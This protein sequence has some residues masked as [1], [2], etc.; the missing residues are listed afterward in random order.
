MAVDARIQRRL[1]LRND[2]R[3]RKRFQTAPEFCELLR[4]EL[5]AS[6]AIRSSRHPPT[7]YQ[8]RYLFSIA[9]RIARIERAAL[10]G[11]FLFTLLES[12]RAQGNDMQEVS[13]EFEAAWANADIR[14]SLGVP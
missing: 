14:L 1:V 11:T 8:F 2:L 5:L 3:V 10:S 7:A 4:A 6:A 9:A 12:L 13:K